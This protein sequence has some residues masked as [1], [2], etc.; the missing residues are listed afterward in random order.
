M[1]GLPRDT[2]LE[3]RRKV[4]E[5]KGLPALRTPIW[6]HG[7]EAERHFYSKSFLF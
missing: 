3:Y 4:A 7:L 6:L 2:I 1:D 5:G